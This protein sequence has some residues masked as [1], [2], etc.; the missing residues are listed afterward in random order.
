VVAGDAP[1]ERAGQ[2]ALRV[3]LAEDNV[4]N[5]KV[6]FRMLER[7]GYRADVAANGVEVLQA[8]RRQPYD[9]VLMDVQMPEM[10]G[11]EA[12]RQIRASFAPDAQP[13]VIAV[14]ANAMTGDRERCLEAGADDYLAKPV[15]VHALS[16]ALQRCSDREPSGDDATLEHAVGAARAALLAYTGEEDPVFVGE[17]ASSYLANAEALLAQARSGVLAGD[18][19]T[20][21]EAVH[22]LKSSSAL[23]EFEALV[24]LCEAVEAHALAGELDELADR[25][26]EAARAFEDL[27]PVLTVLQHR[28]GSAGAPVGEGAGA[29]TVTV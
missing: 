20:A 2:N 14:T 13:C 17:L 1:A 22:A 6:A 3:L 8:L 15:D 7:L 28:A 16:E 5:Q 9:V 25:L 11:L 26:R 27:R 10:D 12:T 24:E 18:A 19:T 4:I 21:A 23:F 29:F